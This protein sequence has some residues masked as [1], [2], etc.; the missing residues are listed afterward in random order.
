MRFICTLCN[1]VVE[2]SKSNA[3]KSTVQENLDEIPE[4]WH[5][6]VCQAGK[7]Y[8]QACNCVFWSLYEKTK[9]DKIA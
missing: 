2:R 9:Y 5:C 4:N 7:E 3:V 6:A 8:L 1:N